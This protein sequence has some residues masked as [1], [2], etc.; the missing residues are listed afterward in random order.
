[1]KKSEAALQ[2]E[3]FMWAW[4][5]YPER[6]RTFFRVKNEGKK[7]M[8]TA[9]KDRSMGVVAG[10]PDMVFMAPCFGVE[11]KTDTGD[12]RDGQIKTM[13]QFERHD[14]EY[15]TIRDKEE[16]INLITKKFSR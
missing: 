10:A 5:T 2:A 4:N 8:R 7:G 3:C 15:Y 6:R 1:M 11:F 9:L 14:V 12:H 13:R 16:F